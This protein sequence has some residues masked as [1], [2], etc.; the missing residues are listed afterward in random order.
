M[1][2]V[3]EVAQRSPF[4]DTG[5]L[6]DPPEDNPGQYASTDTPFVRDQFPAP[7]PAEKSRLYVQTVEEVAA[8]VEAILVRAVALADPAWVPAP[9]VFDATENAGQYAATETPFTRGEPGEPPPFLGGS[10]LYFILVEEIAAAIEPI[11]VRAVAAADPPVPMP[12]RAFFVE[13]AQEVAAAL[14]LLVRAH[15]GDVPQLGQPSRAYFQQVVE[16][17]VGI[18]LAK[19]GASNRGRARSTTA[20]NMDA[21]SLGSTDADTLGG[22]SSD[23]VGRIGSDT[24]E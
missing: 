12:S 16:E 21:A 6:L 17:V 9:K 8:A 4:K 14:E 2:T 19:I 23:T 18:A 24:D 11:F 5:R 3:R 22:T 1:P 13:V 20:G 7:L 15:P 10:R